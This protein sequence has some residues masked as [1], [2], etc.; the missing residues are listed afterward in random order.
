MANWLQAPFLVG[1]KSEHAWT[2]SSAVRLC[3]APDTRGFPVLRPAY[4]F[5][6]FFIGRL[7][8][9][10]FFLADFC[11]AGDRLA[12]M[13]FPLHFRSLIILC[14]CDPPRRPCRREFALSWRELAP[15]M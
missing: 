3:L 4:L 6:I 10:S 7:F 11:F 5:F 12:A 8:R 13:S 9:A 1:H 15:G 2:M 14:E